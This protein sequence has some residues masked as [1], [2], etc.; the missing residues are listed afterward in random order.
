LEVKPQMGMKPATQTGQGNARRRFRLAMVG[1]ALALVLL[2]FSFRAERR[3]ETTAQIES[4]EAAQVD[5]ELATRFQSP[6]ANRMVLVF[7]GLPEP[8]ESGR[9]QALDFIEQDLRSEPGVSAVTSELD[10]SD[11]LFEGSGSG[12]LMLIGL[13]AKGAELESL[14]ARLRARC[15]WLQEHF[16]A[17][18]PA[19]NLEIT[20][21]TPINVDVRK[22]SSEEVQQAELRVVPVTLI[23]LLI[24]F[25]SLVAAL[26]PV[27]V[28]LLAISMTMGAVGLIAEHFHLS[29]LV[30]NLASMLGLGLGIDYALLMVNRYREALA[31]GRDPGA[32]ADLLWKNAGLTLIVSASTVAIGFTVLLFVPIGDIRSIGL[33]GLLVAA[34]SVLL[35][36]LVLPWV[37][38]LL[39]TRI[40]RWGLGITVTGL[41][42]RLLPGTA[43]NSNVREINGG[44]RATWRRLGM[45]VTARPWLSLTLAGAPLVLLALQGRH[46]ALGLPSGDW[47]PPRA[48]SVKAIHKLESMDRAGVVQPIRILLELPVGAPPASTHGWDALSRFTR[49]VAGDRRCAEVLSLTTLVGTDG[50]P[51]DLDT[52]SEQTRKSFLSS[53]GRAALLEV[54]PAAGITA[55]EQVLWVRQLR[56]MNVA[57]VTALPGTTM[58]IGGY[59]AWN[60]DYEKVADEYLPRVIAAVVGGSFVALLI[61][62]R[63]VFVAV[64]AVLLNL[65]SVGASF[66]ALVLVFQDGFGGSVFGVPGGVGKVFMEIPIVSFAIVFGLSMDYEVFLVARVREERR[67]GLGERAAVAEGLACTAG[68][69]TSAAAIMISVFAAF[70]LGGFLA[71]KMMGFTLAVAVLIDATL[72]RMVIGPALLQLAGDWNWWPW[73][74]AGSNAAAASQH[75]D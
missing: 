26:L 5:S 27:G 62:F 37:L 35:C 72:V 1:C 16:H 4:G 18:Y 68:L 75:S 39:G 54:M 9:N 58:R 34:M 44:A 45:A 2:P 57:E 48:E 67:R 23:L 61:G 22:I 14:L 19:L 64:K 71:I 51:A 29:I 43:G 28:G 3:L 25:G 38:G 7:T 30:Q 41:L 6:Y 10:W 52:L 31:E 40:N 33:A 46:I 50:G 12:G 70:T 60:A 42:R 73:G 15:V 24:A 47:F 63:S 53:D 55:S 56:K 13:D 69:I 36:T 20:G 8:Y 11:K 21:E 65:L 74:L 59:A 66:G 49:F 32:A 17:Q